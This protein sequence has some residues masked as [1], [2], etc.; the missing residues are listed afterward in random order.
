MYL[1]AAFTASCF[2]CGAFAVPQWSHPGVLVGAQD[3]ASA[4]LRLQNGV[5]PT[6]SFFHSAA[7]SPQ[8]SA[9]YV[10]FGPPADGVISCGY[11]G[12][13]RTLM[14]QTKN[15]TPQTLQFLPPMACIM[16]CD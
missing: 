14:H 16:L 12:E 11:Y 9:N 7:E 3:I 13:T 10:P 8:G 4:R 1:Y 2:I 15:Q 6:Y 5:E